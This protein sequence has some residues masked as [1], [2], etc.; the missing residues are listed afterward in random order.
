[1]FWC[2]GVQLCWLGFS[3]QFASPVLLPCV[4]AQTF[5][6]VW[7]EVKPFLQDIQEEKAFV[8]MEMDDLWLNSL[9]M[10]RV[11]I[12]WYPVM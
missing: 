5:L 7:Y 11:E 9:R 2:W 6:S 10:S 3:Q 8:M 1:M 4:P 12:I